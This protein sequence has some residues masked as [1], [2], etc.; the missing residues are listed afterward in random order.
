[1]KKKPL[2]NKEIIISRFGVNIAMPATRALE[3]IG[4]KK[5]SQLPK[6]SEKEL[7]ELHGMGPRAIKLLKE[8]LKLKGL[9]F[10]NS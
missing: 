1:M 8:Q 2:S 3:S 10:K 7:L 6:Y 4:V 9:R 5:L